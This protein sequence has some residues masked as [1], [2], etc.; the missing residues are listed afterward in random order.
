MTTY[1]D[2]FFDEIQAGAL[3]SARRIVPRVLELVGPESVVDVGCGLGAWLSVFQA[4]GVADVLGIDGDYVDR[5]QLGIPESRFLARDLAEPLVVD[6]RFDL[7]MSVEVA[8]HLP[9]GAAE[10]FVGSLVGLAPVVLFSAAVPGQPGTGHVN[11]QWLDYWIDRFSARGF[12][13]IDCIRWEVWDSPEVDWWYAQNALVYVDRERLDDYPELRALLASRACDPPSVVHPALYRRQAWWLEM[14]EVARRVFGVVGAGAKIVVID[15]E[16]GLRYAFPE[17]LALPFVE[18]HGAYWGKPDDDAAAIAELERARGNGAG[19]VV[20]AASCS[21]WF[22]Y[23]PGF[24]DQL[25]RYPC[26]LDGEDVRVFDVR[27]P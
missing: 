26:V 24:R 2:Q 21:W 6:R 9:A 20:I 27:K 17:A 25:E 10:S 16:T 22:D 13:A 15:D 1:D 19:Y 14:A 5:E 7:A 11:A 3:S 23:Y 4:N 12:V 8:E 18:R